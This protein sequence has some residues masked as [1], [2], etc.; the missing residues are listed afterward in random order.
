VYTNNGETFTVNTTI[1]AGTTLTT[2]TLSGGNPLSSGTLTKSS[3]TGDATITFSAYT[4]TGATITLP[5]NTRLLNAAQYYLV[6]S[7]KLEVFLNGQELVNNTDYNEIGSVHSFSNQITMLIPLVVGDVLDLRI[8]TGG[9]SGLLGPAGPT[10]P[11]GAAGVAGHDA[12][13]GP[14]AISTKTG[15]YSVLLGDNVLLANCTTQAILF[16]L[17][18]AGAGSGYVF[19]FKKVDSSSNAMQVQSSGGALIDGSSSPKSTIVQWE[20]FTLISDGTNWYV[21]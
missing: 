10:G 3:G 17:P 14:V 6:N 20:E 16:T 8:A 11:A 4:F 21:F 15:D 13:G 19:Y 5:N 9:G 2:T 1:V 7:A 12:A 18:T